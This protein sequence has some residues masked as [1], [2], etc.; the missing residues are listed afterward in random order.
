[1]FIFNGLD[2]IVFGAVLMIVIIFSSSHSFLFLFIITSIKLSKF[3]SAMYAEMA[4]A[5]KEQWNA[6]AE[7]DRVRYLAELAEYV[8]PPGYDA[9]GDAIEYAQVLQ[10]KKGS[11]ARDVNAPKKSE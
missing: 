1:M 4:P 11:A 9:K 3:T 8:P 7:A 10:A 5:E 2:I 6:N